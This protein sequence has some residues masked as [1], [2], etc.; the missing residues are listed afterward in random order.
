MRITKIISSIIK[1]G[2]RVLTHKPYGDVTKNNELLSPF[3]LDANPYPN[4]KGAQHAG[5]TNGRGVISG[6][7]NKF[8]DALSGERRMYSTLPDGTEIVTEIFQLNNGSILIRGGISGGV[9]KYSL[10]IDNDGTVSEEVILKTITGNIVINGNL[11]VN[12]KITGTV[13]EGA[14]KDIGTHT[15]PYTDDGN[16]LVTGPPI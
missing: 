4:I 11:T 15:H 1:N 2:L 7:F 14:G 16:P 12:G 5:T 8:L 10:L 6:F 3:G 13:I 9:E